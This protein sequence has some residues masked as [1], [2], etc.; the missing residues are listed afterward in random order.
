VNRALRRAG[1]RLEPVRSWDD[2]FK[3]WIAK[4][5][6]TGQDP[7]DLADQDWGTDLLAE[8]VER[9]Y[10]PHVTPDSTV[11]EVGPG[12]GRLS[13]HLIGRCHHLILLETSR[14]ACDWLRGYL[15]GRGSFEVHQ[16]DGWPD[17]PLPDSTADA[18]FANGVVEH[19][20]TEELYWHLRE[21]RRLLKPAALRC[22]TSTT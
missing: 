20:P 7:N 8:S 11:V 17:F 5:T 3:R 1:I 10:L 2:A 14:V 21:W 18:V 22:S 19:L 12:T 16:I 9:H 4:G 15:A 13:R 6:E